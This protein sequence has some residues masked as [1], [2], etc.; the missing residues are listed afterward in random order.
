MGKF[1]RGSL[2]PPAQP[3]A[4][5]DG[6]NNPPPASCLIDRVAYIAD[7]TNASTA[8]CNTTDNTDNH[9]VTIQVTFVVGDPPQ[10][11]YLCAHCIGSQFAYEPI[12]VA[13][14]GRLALLAIDIGRS[15]S[16]RGRKHYIY[17]AGDASRGMDPSLKRLPDPDPAPRSLHRFYDGYH[18]GLLLR[19]RPQSQPKLQG[20]VFLRSYRAQEAEEHVS[21]VVAGLFR[22]HKPSATAHLFD[23]YLYS[24]DTNKWSIQDQEAPLLLLQHQ[25]QRAGGG[26]GGFDFVT[27]KAISIGGEH[28][29]MCFVDLQQGILQ[30]NVLDSNPGLR[31]YPLPPPLEPNP[32]TMVQ[33][34]P[35]AF[36][37]VAIIDGGRRIKCAQLHL[38]VTLNCEDSNWGDWTVPSYHG[39]KAATWSMDTTHPSSGWRQDSEVV[40]ASEI[41]S[42]IHP[43]LL[44]YIAT[45]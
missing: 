16:G 35:Q 40:H 36:R 32:V 6:G 38:D 5:V 45:A 9:G 30:C 14:E 29:T 39:W 31:Y 26:G 11:S 15:S 34:Y 7:V 1:K 19:P 10:V 8:T 20:G 24:S 25:Q 22:K 43:A 12:I 37:D 13:T 3:P 41:G 18:L 17:Y 28:A 21:Y 33:S 23:L 27:N 2:N 44:Q 42:T 4:V